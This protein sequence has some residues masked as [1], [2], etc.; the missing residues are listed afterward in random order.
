MRLHVYG[1]PE[2]IDSIRKKTA[3]KVYRCIELRQFLIAIFD[4]SRRFVSD[5]SFASRPF[6]FVWSSAFS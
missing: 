6:T 3:L 4:F 5:R 1:K 2:N